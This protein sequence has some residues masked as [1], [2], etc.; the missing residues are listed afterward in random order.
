MLDKR[1][2]DSVL[3]RICDVLAD[4]DGGL[5]GSEIGRYLGQLGIPDPG[6]SITKRHRLFAAL[7]AQQN[8]DRSWACVVRFIKV[9]MA[10]VNYTDRQT[11]FDDRRSRLNEVLGFAGLVLRSDGQL[12]TAKATTKLSEVQERKRRLLDEMHR[13]GVHAEVLRYCR[14]ELLAGDCFDMTFEAT[15]GLMERVRHLTGLTSDG[16]ALVEAAFGLGKDRPPRPMLALNG[17]RDETELAEQKGMVSLMIGLYG[18]FRNPAG[19]APKLRWHVDEQD[20]LDLL[21]TLSFVHRRLDR[22][23]PL[24]ST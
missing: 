11:S 13:R 20:A 17:L 12:A 7:Q 18:T 16:A 8:R 23:V 6:S 5:T 22:G 2:D 14:E 1:F 3:Q 4:T 19:H 21:T 9:T 10:P 24:R 15:K